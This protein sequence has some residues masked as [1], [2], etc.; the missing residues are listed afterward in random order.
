M[1]QKKHEFV[2]MKHETLHLSQ[3]TQRH[4]K[5]YHEKSF[6]PHHGHNKENGSPLNLKGQGEALILT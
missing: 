5:Q 3:W 1:Q 4:P 6:I 2:H